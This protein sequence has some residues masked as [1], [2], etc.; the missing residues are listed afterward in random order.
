M[1]LQYYFDEGSGTSV[2]DTGTSAADLTITPSGTSAWETDGLGT[3]YNNNNN[4]D[5]IISSA[6]LNGTAVASAY[7]GGATTMFVEVVTDIDAVIA[8]RK[9][10]I[11][12]LGANVRVDCALMLLAHEDLSGYILYSAFGATDGEV[13]DNYRF[14]ET[15]GSANDLLGRHCYQASIDTTIAT[16]SDRVVNY[17][18]GVINAEIFEPALNAEFTLANNGQLDLTAWHTGTSSG[19]LDQL[20]GAV[21]WF[22][23]DVTLPAEADIEDRAAALLLD[24]DVD[25][26]GGGG[27]GV[28]EGTSARIAVG[29]RMADQS[30]LRAVPHYGNLGR[31]AQ[32]QNL[33]S[34]MRELLRGCDG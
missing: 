10:V 22:A 21:R 19:T 34:P 16:A 32:M 31:G 3:G 12:A 18:D 15:T 24:D 4:D 13:P 20:D 30:R 14:S 26:E 29:I 28:A 9:Q 1:L 17:I 2:N 11:A 25:P 7:S 8:S 5:A 27:G 23:L 33:R 6:N